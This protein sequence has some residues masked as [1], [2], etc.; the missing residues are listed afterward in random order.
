MWS[1]GALLEL[2]NR[3]KLEAFIRDQFD[4]DLPI[5]EEG[6]NHTMFEFFVDKEGKLVMFH[7][8]EPKTH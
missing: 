6:S 7:L 3:V 2:D 4:L 1:I 8:I 5:I